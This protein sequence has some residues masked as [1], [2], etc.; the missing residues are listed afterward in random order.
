ML[1]TPKTI[2]VPC[3]LICACD[4]V[5]GKQGPTFKPGISAQS[6]GAK[7]VYLELLTIPPGARQGA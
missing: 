4:A 5:T 6:V 3:A 2:P 7:G 1:F